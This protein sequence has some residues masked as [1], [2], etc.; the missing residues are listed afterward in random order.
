MSDWFDEDMPGQD[1]G[2]ERYYYPERFEEEI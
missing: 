2:Y 1:D